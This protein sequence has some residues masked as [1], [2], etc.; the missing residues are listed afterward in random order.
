M[1]RVLWVFGL[2]SSGKTT[3]GTALRD[4]LRAENRPV[5]LLDGDEL[6]SGLCSDLGFSDEDRSE[7]VRRAAHI[8]R[9][10]A[11]QGNT[12]IAAFVTP[13]EHHRALVRQILG[14][15]LSFIHTDCPLEVCITRDVKGLYSKAAVQQMTGLT[16]LQE[17]FEP[18]TDVQLTLRTQELTIDQSVERLRQRCGL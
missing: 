9:L 1:N 5:V 3:L 17:A 4:A 11:A 8:A 13:G 14:T 2:P 7:N 6:R 10:L 12:V 15:C 18:P 16:G